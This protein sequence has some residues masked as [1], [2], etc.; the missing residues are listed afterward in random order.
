MTKILLGAV[1]LI[2][3]GVGLSLLLSW[4]VMWLWNESLI[5]AVDGVHPITWF[6]AWGISALCGILFQSNISISK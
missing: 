4:P 2:A 5:G 3:L 1:G 6:Q